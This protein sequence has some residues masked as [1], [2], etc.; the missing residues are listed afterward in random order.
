MATE[1]KRVSFEDVGG[2][3]GFRLKWSVLDHWADVEAWEIASRIDDEKGTPQFL[4]ESLV[5][6]LPFDEKLPKYLD[7]LVKWD[8]C[9]EFEFGNIHWCGPRYYLKHFALLKHI[10][11]RAQVLM[12]REYIEDPWPANGSDMIDPKDW[13]NV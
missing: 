4:S 10:Y 11:N 5:E 6:H 12:R 3:F 13:P 1:E 2:E 8:G 9:S 7:G